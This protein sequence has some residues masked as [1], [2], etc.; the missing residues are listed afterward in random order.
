[1]TC[2][3]VHLIWVNVLKKILRMQRNVF[4]HTAADVDGQAHFCQVRQNERDHADQEDL[5]KAHGLPPAGIDN[6]KPDGA[7]KVA[8][9]QTNQECW[10]YEF[11]VSLDQRIHQKKHEAEKQEAHHIASGRTNHMTNA[12]LEAREDRETNGTK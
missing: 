5:P 9:R 7:K 10:D 6:R 3:P 8:D 2:L 12:T 1:M 11:P 4:P